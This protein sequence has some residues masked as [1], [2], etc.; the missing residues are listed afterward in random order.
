MDMVEQQHS[1]ELEQEL[2]GWFDGTAMAPEPVQMNRLARFSAAVPKAVTPWFSPFA[3]NLAGACCLTLGLVVLSLQSFVGSSQPWPVD[4]V[5]R[6][7]EIHMAFNLDLLE[8]S[9]QW[10]S[11]ISDVGLD[12]LHGNGRVDEDLLEESFQALLD[13]SNKR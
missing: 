3:R 6:T 10:E 4:A 13:E 1:D 5:V 12:L 9:V 8:Q 2:Q 7:P 11:D